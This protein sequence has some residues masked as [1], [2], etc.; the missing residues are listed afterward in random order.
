[1]RTMSNGQKKAR[2][3]IIPKPGGKSHEIEPPSRIVMEYEAGRN[4][5]VCGVEP[6]TENRFLGTPLLLLAYRNGYNA[7]LMQRKCGKVAK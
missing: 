7:G 3:A 6:K 5:G 2:G 1:M 4:D